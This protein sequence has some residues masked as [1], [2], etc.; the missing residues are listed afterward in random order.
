L[1]DDHEQHV[2]IP[3]ASYFADEHSIDTL[4]L[5]VI[6]DRNF[7]ADEVVDRERW[8]T[9]RPRGIIITKAL[10]KALFPPGDALDK[11]A[12]LQGERQMAPIIGIVDTLQA[13]WTSVARDRLVD[14]SI[15]EPFRFIS[16]TSYYVVRAKPARLAGVMKAAE[17]ALI[18]ADPTRIIEKMQSLSVARGEAYRD[19]RGLAIILTVICGALLA[20][21]ICGIAGLTSYWV[22]QLRR[23]IG[24]RRALGTTRAIIFYYFQT[25]NFLVVSVG[26]VVGAA[27][28]IALNTWMVSRFQMTH[29]QYSYAVVSAVIVLLLGQLAVLWPALQAAKNVA[30]DSGARNGSHEFARPSMMREGTQRLFRSLFHSEPNAFRFRL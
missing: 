16:P 18:V 13:P 21:T 6:A 8:L 20:A 24:I 19:D 27:L 11:S 3:S 17:S 22:A 9:M 28:A 23:Q 12:F 7:Q 25:E 14:N 1:N 26:T 4:G 5:R 29:L 10:A 2:R 30:G 15:L